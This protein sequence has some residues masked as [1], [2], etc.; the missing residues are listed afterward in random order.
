MGF[1][2]YGSNQFRYA[3]SLRPRLDKSGYPMHVQLF[4]ISEPEW[5]AA[6][7]AVTIGN[8]TSNYEWV[9]FG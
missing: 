3:R 9:N 7:Y 4:C 5:Q 2:Y 8:G 1:G 6:T